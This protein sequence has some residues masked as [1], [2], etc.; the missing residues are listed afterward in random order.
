MRLKVMTIVGVLVVGAVYMALT[1][2]EARVGQNADGHKY[3]EIEQLWRDLP[4]YP[5]MVE[6]GSSSN[7]V[8]QKA[9][10]DKTFKSDTPYDEV[11]QYYLNKL[12]DQGWLFDQERQL[13]NWGRDQGGRHL[14]FRN[15]ERDLTIEYAGTADFG[16]NY[17]I[18]I[19]WYQP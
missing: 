2:Y 19:Y 13:T 17:G 12:R 9:S 11:K 4:I 8:A 1:T 14:K 6:I 3:K 5:G 18:G 10:I 16:W 15:G 7:S